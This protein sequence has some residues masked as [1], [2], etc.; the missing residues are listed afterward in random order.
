M[1]TFRFAYTEKCVGF[2]DVVAENEDDARVI[3]E[4][5]S[6][7]TFTYINDVDTEIGKL[8]ETIE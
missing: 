5:F 2:I 6:G 7:D 1:K 8:I 4:S 3:A